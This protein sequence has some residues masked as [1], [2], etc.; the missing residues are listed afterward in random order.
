M[1][2]GLAYVPTFPP[3]R[4]RDVARM[5]ERAGL[6]ELWVWEDCFKQSAIASAAAALAWTDT[7]TVGIGLMPAPL[8]NV[9]LCAMELATLE[10]MFPGRL[11]AGVGHG[12]PSWMAQVGGKVAS[13]LTLLEE[14]ADALRRL[15]GGNSVTVGGRYVTLDDVALDWA[16]PEPPPLMIGGAGP[17]S[18]ALAARLGDG[19]LLGTAMTQAEVRDACSVILEARDGAV[20]PVVATMVV[21]TGPGA[22]ERVRREIQHWGR[23][24]GDDVGVGGT[25]EAI[26]ESLRELRHAGVTSVAIHPTRDEPELPELLDVIAGDVRELLR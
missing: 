12:V 2:L 20:H 17:R 9:A 21:A 6:D 7:I 26:A 23:G 19:N 18:L 16:P 8:R 11:I 14:Y 4:L 15:L 3:E 10:R 22:H 24:A 13:P 1:Q 25:A 5:A